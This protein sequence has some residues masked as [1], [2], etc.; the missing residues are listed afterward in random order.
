MCPPA[1][2]S[3][4]TT[5]GLS[6]RPLHFTV[7]CIELDPPVGIVR[8]LA[9]PSAGIR[10]VVVGSANRKPISIV[11]APSTPTPSVSNPTYLDT[12]PRFYTTTSSE[13]R[14]LGATPDMVATTTS[15]IVNVPSNA[16]LAQLASSTP[17]TPASSPS[18]SA[19]TLSIS[20]LGLHLLLTHATASSTLSITVGQHQ[21]DISQ[22]FVELCALNRERRRG[23]DRV[24]LHLDLCI[25]ELTCI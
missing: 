15:Y 16:T 20:V 3:I 5:E 23:G 2:D 22:N 12:Q 6:T 25:A 19:S 13:P 21:D 11:T 24:P 7:M 17:P 9:G 18:F 10:E 14:T 8:H 4:L 1:W